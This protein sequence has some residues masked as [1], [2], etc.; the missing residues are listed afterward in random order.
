MGLTRMTFSADLHTSGEIR[1]AAADIP[2]NSSSGQPE[3]PPEMAAMQAQV[4]RMMGDMWLQMIF[5]FPEFPEEA[6]SPGDE[7]EEKKRLKMG[8]GAQGFGS[9]TLVKTVYILEEVSKGLAYFSVKQ[10]SVTKTSA[11]MGTTAET[12]SAGKGDAIFD[13]KEG[14]WLEFT[15]KSR[16][17]VSMGNIPGAEAAPGSNTV[18]SINK[19]TLEKQ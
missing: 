15:T 12:K 7:F 13:L 8:G 6:L 19:I 18:L 5:W 11:A 9:Q 10:R 14:M 4:G 17:N 1:N 3:I 16:H 2:E